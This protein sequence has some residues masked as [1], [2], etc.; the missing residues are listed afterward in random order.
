M[1]PVKT[2]LH[3]QRKRLAELGIKTITG[4]SRWVYF[5]FK[6]AK[7]LVVGPKIYAKDDYFHVPL[8]EWDTETLTKGC[9]QIIYQCAGLPTP[10]SA[11]T[12]LTETDLEQLFALFHFIKIGDVQPVE[13]N[14]SVM[15]FN[16]RM[17]GGETV[18]YF[19]PPQTV[20]SAESSG[21]SVLALSQRT[22]PAGRYGRILP[23]PCII[24][25]PTT[26]NK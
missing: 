8:P 18:I 20:P 23:K 15:L 26:L 7:F 3:I 5:S 16:H 24:G 2:L 1:G 21:D 6:A 14:I 19:N 12:D 9:E 4:S 13:N 11:F 10:A 17:D 25:I 22:I